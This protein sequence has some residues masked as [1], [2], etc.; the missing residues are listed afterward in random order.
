M[1]APNAPDPNLP[2]QLNAANLN[3]Q[4]IADLYHTYTGKKVLVSQ[5]ASGAEVSFIVPGQMTYAEAARVIEKRLVMEGLEIIPDDDDASF[6]KL[7]LAN[8]Q[9]SGPKPLGPPVG[10][11]IDDL[12]SQVSA[13]G[14]V[15]Y[16]MALQYLK[17]DDA[18]RAFQAVVQQFGSAGTVAAIPNAGSVVISGNLP[19]VRMLVELKDRIDVPSAQVGTKFVEVTFADVEDLA[20]RLNEIFNNQR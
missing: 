16:V 14:F 11:D 12:E 3:G 17:P 20:T 4:D 6:V 18:L 19:L 10:D 2:A 15:T 9:T 8:S 5:E 7:V 1:A 13:D